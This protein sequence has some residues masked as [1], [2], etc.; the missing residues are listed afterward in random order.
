MPTTTTDVRTELKPQRLASPSEVWGALF[1]AVQL[2]RIF[3]DSK[4]F[5]DMEPRQPPAAILA[6]YE[7]SRKQDG[8]DLLAFVEQHFSRPAATAQTYQSDPQGSLRAHIASMW[9]ILLRRPDGDAVPGSSLLPLTHSYIVPGE[10]FGEIYYWD[11][12]FTMLG[13]EQS[14]K[15]A[16]VD[17]MVDNFAALINRYGHIPNGNR[18]YFLSRSQPP[19]FSSMVELVAQREGEQA[20]VR[21]QTALATEYAYWMDGADRLQPGQAYRHLV[22]AAD[23]LLLNR[24]WDDLAAPREEAYREDIA[25]ADPSTRPA[26][27]I[28]RNLRA[29][30]ASGWDY[31]SRWLADGHTLASIRTIELLPVDL[32]CLLLHLEQTLA[33]SYA[34]SGDAQSATLYR[35]HARSRAAA[36]KT[37]LWDSAN[38]I[39]CDYFW[40][41]QQTSPAV[42]AAMLYPLFFG[43][44][45]VQQATGVAQCISEKL[46]RS[47]GLATTTVNSGQQWDAPNGW[48]PL[49]WIAIAGLRRYGYADLAR[50]IASRWVGNNV[51]RFRRTGGLLEKY[52][53]EDGSDAVDAEYVTQHGFGWT[54]GVL[55]KLLT[56]YP[57]LDC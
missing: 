11:S 51:A 15:H 33:K 19:F 24:Y 53:V 3:V 20:Y 34:A 36:I 50:E 26:G 48:A 29:G 45:T 18:S 5:V 9:E 7:E 41:R 32:N 39:F 54:N 1:D 28:W 37:L 17:G 38:A 46:L 31:S 42:T 22:S 57:E 14:G 12:Y 43:V 44:A 23:G 35:R 47:G 8:F 56:M 55:L 30:A 4:T 52:N 49:Q 6:L 25:T 21:W 13:L 10:R 40:R 16:L 2:Q 27:E